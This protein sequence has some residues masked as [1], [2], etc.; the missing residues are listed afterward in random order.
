[1]ARPHT[2]LL[3]SSTLLP[4][5]DTSRGSLCLQSE[6]HAPEAGLHHPD[7]KGWLQAAEAVGG[8][9]SN[10]VMSHF[11]SSLPSSVI[12]GLNYSSLTCF[13][14]LNICSCGFLCR[15]A[16]SCL[17]QT[18]NSNTTTSLSSPFFLEPKVMS[19][20]L[21]SCGL[22]LPLLPPYFCLLL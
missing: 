14:P 22:Y 4:S 6:G 20:S 21:Y 2:R 7:L 12:K 15:K 9:S 17:N 3:T 13:L 8:T 5:S 10:I 19:S 18:L 16:F 11:F 1:M